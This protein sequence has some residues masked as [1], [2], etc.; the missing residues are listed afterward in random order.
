MKHLITVYSMAQNHFITPSKYQVNLYKE[1]TLAKNWSEIK[2]IV[3]EYRDL[4][5]SKIFHKIIKIRV[6]PYK[7][8]HYKVSE[9][10]PGPV[11][12][13]N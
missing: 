10:F 11:I 4:E 8:Q 2:T 7:G 3:K 13:I 5:D 12:N 9:L 6:N 1:Q